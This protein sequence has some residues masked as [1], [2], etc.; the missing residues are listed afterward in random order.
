MENLEG[1]SVSLLRRMSKRIW[2]YKKVVF[3][4]GNL[5]SSKIWHAKTPRCSLNCWISVWIAIIQLSQAIC[6]THSIFSRIN[7]RVFIRAS[8]SSSD[9]F[10]MVEKTRRMIFR[11]V[12]EKIIRKLQIVV[13]KINCSPL[14]T[15][16]LLSRVTSLLSSRQRI[17]DMAVTWKESKKKT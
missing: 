7:Y 14:A 17:K 6:N 15:V 9:L 5:S 1:G 13:S 3:S 4:T 8:N 11:S 2:K 10:W 12:I 16:H